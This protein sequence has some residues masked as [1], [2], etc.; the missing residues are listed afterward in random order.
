M[1]GARVKVEGRGDTL[2]AAAGLRGAEQERRRIAASKARCEAEV[3][4]CVEEVERVLGVAREELR[5]EVRRLHDQAEEKVEKSELVLQGSGTSPTKLGGG[6]E[7]R[8]V[9][10]VASRPLAELLTAGLGTFTT[11]PLLPA[12]LCLHLDSLPLKVGAIVTCSVAAVEEQQLPEETLRC[13]SVTVTRGGAVIKVVQGLD[14][15]GRRLVI[16]FTVETAGRYAVAALLAGRHLPGSPVLLALPADPATLLA[17]LGLTTLGST[18]VPAAVGGQIHNLKA[19]MDEEIMKKGES[20]MEPKVRAEEK[21]KPVKEEIREVVKAKSINDARKVAKSD[22]KG[23]KVAIK[24]TT[25]SKENQKEE[26]VLEKNV[27]KLSEKKVVS[28]WS[29]GEEV[30]ARWADDGVWYRA[31]VEAR[32]PAGTYTVTFLDYGNQAEVAE[33]AMVAHRGKVPKAEVEMIDE[34]VLEA[35]NEKPIEAKKVDKLEKHIE[36]KL[37]KVEFVEKKEEKLSAKKVEKK[38]EKKLEKKVEKKE[39]RQVEKQVEKQ[40]KKST[41]VAKNSWVKGEEGLARWEEDG[42]WYRAKV[43]SVTQDGVVRVVFTDYGNEDDVVELARSVELVADAEVLDE[44]VE[45]AVTPVK[46]P[47]TPST[48][49]TAGAACY[50]LYQ[51]LWHP[52]TV[53]ALLSDDLVTVKN[54]ATMSFI[55]VHKDCV[56]LKVEDIP[57]GGKLASP[58]VKE[59]KVQWKVGERCVA[60]WSEDEVWYR[61]EVVATAASAYTVLFVD[62]GNEA[63]AVPADMVRSGREAPAGAKM[64]E[65]VEKVEAAPKKKEDPKDKVGTQRS[66]WVEG[67]EGVARWEEDGVWYRAKVLGVSQAGTARVVFTD[68]GNE[69]EVFELARS[70]ELLADS[71]VLDENVKKAAT[72]VVVKEVMAAEV[73]AVK[74][75]PKR[76]LGKPRKAEAEA[77]PEVKESKPKAPAAASPPPP[78]LACCVCN[79]V[80]KAMHRL[81]CS[82]RPVCWNCAVKQLTPGHTC[83]QCRAAPV[84]TTSHLEKDSA[85]DLYVKEFLATGRL[86]ES[87][88]QALRS[89]RRAALAEG[90]ACVARWTEDEVWYNARVEEVKE[91]GAVVLF[92]DYGN[93]DYALWS[94]VV[95]DAASLPA[96]AVCDEHVSC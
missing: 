85:L 17:T 2:A 92:T 29:V 78:E 37:E 74:P 82:G 31:R 21:V 50:V 23:A 51:E 66:S 55:G 81:K 35:K 54:T 45:K 1:S 95:P 61:A 9:R 65:H 11:S 58:A 84:Y 96:D 62:Y 80:K 69:D 59:K 73:P 49:L 6:G 10:F 32:D 38:V 52:A 15:A 70:A 57:K 40:V 63:E 25:V 88:L 83:W 42:V 20:K 48:S 36:K 47:K 3:A 16:R 8:A 24:E 94:Q 4:S 30:V 87:H 7:F 26:T 56:V 43:L 64:D 12:Q 68:Y 75:Q 27:K 19:V 41:S 86:E 18:G 79:T 67:E 93:S 39:E 44:H 72:P 13:L 5:G 90:Q 22:L 60:R 34:F 77:A 28:R 89:R 53:H 71:E 46:A 14:A 91:G 76:A 33:A